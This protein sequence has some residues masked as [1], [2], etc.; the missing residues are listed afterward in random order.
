MK[1]KAKYITVDQALDLIQTGDKIILGMAAS[2]PQ[3]F[4]NRLHEVTKRGVTDVL[5]TNCL[6]INQKHL[7]LL[8]QNIIMPFNLILG[9][10]HQV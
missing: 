5:V 2:E 6:P 8:I 10:T 7:I 4:V 1:T 3:L 9:F